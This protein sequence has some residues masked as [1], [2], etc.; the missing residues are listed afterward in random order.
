MD[1]IT[2]VEITKKGKLRIEADDV[3]IRT[4]VGRHGREG[5]DI[6]QEGMAVIELSKEEAR[7]LAGPLKEFL[8]E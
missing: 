3:I 4:T 2:G 5:M 1:K 8:G 6:E 7:K